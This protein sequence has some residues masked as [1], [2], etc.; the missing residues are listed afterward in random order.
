MVIFED[1][2]AFDPK[3]PKFLAHLG[4][5]ARSDIGCKAVLMPTAKY[6][7][8][9]ISAN[10]VIIFGFDVAANETSILQD[11]CSFACSHDVERSFVCCGFGFHLS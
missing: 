7:S 8:L 2:S 3:V 11:L 4:S 6:S 9:T 10:S 5:V 1:I